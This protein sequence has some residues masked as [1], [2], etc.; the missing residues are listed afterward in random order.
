MIELS[1]IE[2]LAKLSRI[3]LSN[4][5]KE[6]LR[7]DLDSILGYVAEIKEVSGKN[8]TGAEPY[9][10]NVLR[11]DEAPHVSGMYT[12]ALL[13]SAPEREEQY[14]RVKKIL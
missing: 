7:T 6:S 13:S 3:S 8:A 2:K 5:E 10:R 11:L 12:E 1:D 14:V 4:A 9:H